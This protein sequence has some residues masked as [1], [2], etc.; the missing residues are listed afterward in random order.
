MERVKSLKGGLHFLL[1]LLTLSLRLSAQNVPTFEM[2]IPGTNDITSLEVIR[3]TKE[4]YACSQ[5]I[6]AGRT[7]VFI[8]KLDTAGN[9]TR[10]TEYG[11]SAFNIV[12]SRATAGGGL[13]LLGGIDTIYCLSLAPNGAVAWCKSFYLPGQLLTGTDIIEDSY[14]E[15]VISGSI[16]RGDFLHD[17]FLLKLD[18]DGNSI[19]MNRFKNE[20]E[21]DALC[22]GIIQ[23]DDTIIFCSTVPPDDYGFL[24]NIRLSK[25]SLSDG[26]LLSVTDLLPEEIGFDQLKIYDDLH[27]GYY[28]RASSFIYHSPCQT[29][30]ILR[31]DSN[32]QLLNNYSI[33]GAGIAHGFSV[34][35]DGILHAGYQCR[36]PGHPYTSSTLTK[37]SP[38]GQVVFSA[39]YSS[40]S[41]Q[42][43]P[44]FT[45]DTLVVISGAVR[46]GNQVFA[47]GRK[48]G[49]GFITALNNFSLSQNNCSLIAN[50]VRLAGEGFNI[51]EGAWAAI[52]NETVVAT[53][54]PVGLTN[55]GLTRELAIC[56]VSP[57]LYVDQ[58][59]TG[60]NDGSSWPNAY[61]SLATAIDKMNVTTG[62][63]TILVAA[64]TYTPAPDEGFI[65]SKLHTVILGGYPTGG[66]SRDAGVHVVILQGGVRFEKSVR[67]DGFKV[68]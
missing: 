11:L 27:G 9:I 39:H 62:I 46:I 34:L 60:L 38:G 42:T 3:G 54:L 28:I 65:F 67:F 7:A 68:L 41:I 44:P 20:G 8:M 57:V 25:V 66:G 64:G 47:G 30:F 55:P 32:L 1:L 52:M 23:K 17:P 36:P 13:I 61:T 6:N 5:N 29:D 50:D 10:Q 16:D 22:G 58:H 37:V 43:R 35:S 40:V 19:W 33:V 4:L 51:V 48:N 63:D 14:G 45:P 12:Q 21:R 59:A 31:L 18:K 24:Q 2:T 53:D 15:F 26:S 49:K 56:N